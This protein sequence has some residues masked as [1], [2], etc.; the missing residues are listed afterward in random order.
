MISDH[1]IDPIP[2]Q[3]MEGVSVSRGSQG[4]RRGAAVINELDGRT[5]S[6]ARR[7]DWIYKVVVRTIGRRTKFVLRRGSYRSGVRVWWLLTKLFDVAN[8]ILRSL[9]RRQNARWTAR[10]LRKPKEHELGYYAPLNK[11]GRQAMAAST[12]GD[13]KS[14]FWRQ[15]AA[16]MGR[17]ALKLENVAA[18][19]SNVTALLVSLWLV[20]SAVTKVSE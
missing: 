15:T 6:G 2:L 20:I 18:E 12:A 17:K 14:Q 1:Q 5:W 19:M 11:M 4:V 9:K 10:E 7:V 3:P 13:V 16:R 8:W